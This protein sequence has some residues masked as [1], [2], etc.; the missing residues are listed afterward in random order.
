MKKTNL[1]KRIYASNNN[2]F[3]ITNR[4]EYLHIL[5]DHAQRANATT[6]FYERLGQFSNKFEHMPYLFD[7]KMKN[8]G[9]HNQLGFLDYYASNDKVFFTLGNEERDRTFLSEIGRSGFFCFSTA[10]TDS[11]FISRHFVGLFGNNDNLRSLQFF[12]QLFVRNAGG[13]ASVIDTHDMF[14]NKRFGTKMLLKFSSLGGV[15]RRRMFGRYDKKPRPDFGLRAS[16]SARA[17]CKASGGNFTGFIYDQVRQAF[18]VE[19]AFKFAGPLYK[20]NEKKMKRW[21]KFY[22]EAKGR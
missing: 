3:F 21:A 5:D 17:L 4:Y 2:L 11:L 9:V 16:K 13:R 12:L 8:F 10:D 1:I 19:R 7:I 15:H 6:I 22:Q 14:I 18:A 20:G